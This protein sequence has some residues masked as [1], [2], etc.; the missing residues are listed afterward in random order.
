[1]N[2]EQI[3]RLQVLSAQA[4]SLS[5]LL[6]GVGKEAFQSLSDQAQD[7]VLWLL[8]DLLCEI[9]GIVSGGVRHA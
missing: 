2:K 5:V 3:N 8:S 9:D 4:S 6:Y 7:H 1:M